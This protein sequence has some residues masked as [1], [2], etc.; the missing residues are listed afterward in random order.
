[1]KISKVE[2]T[3]VTVPFTRPEI[4]AQGARPCI[5]SVILEVTTDDGITGLGETLGDERAAAEIE[6]MVCPGLDVF[7]L[8]PLRHRYSG[9][10]SLYAA[11]EMALLDIQGKAIGEPVHKLFGGA[12][13]RKV[14]YMYYL[15]R[16]HP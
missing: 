14:A 11:I 5:T 10:S 6:G 3:V 15:L 4:W 16:D 12:V 13:R 7:E 8:E 9:R 2:T 1:M